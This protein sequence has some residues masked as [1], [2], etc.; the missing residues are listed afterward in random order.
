MACGR[1]YRRALGDADQQLL[2]RHS[3]YAAGHPRLLRHRPVHDRHPHRADRRCGLPCG[4]QPRPLVSIFIEPAKALFLNNAINHGIFSPI[5]ASQ[6]AETG[7]SIMYMLE[8]NPGP[9]LV[10][11]WPTASSARTTP[12]ASPPARDHPPAGR[13]PRDLL[14]HPDEPVA[15]DGLQP[16]GGIDDLGFIRTTKWAM[17][18][19]CLH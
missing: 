10:S 12:P 11:C 16:P 9:G 17:H 13:H 19:L 8:A 4:A 18:G 5:G 1:P 2:H 15:P 7:R 6:A 14:Q 3:G